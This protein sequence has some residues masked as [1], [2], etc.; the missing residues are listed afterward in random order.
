MQH[1]ERTGYRK[2]CT[3]TMH[4]T[5]QSL[6]SQLSQH[7][8]SWER[9]AA[10]EQMSNDASQLSVNLPAFEN[11]ASGTR[12]LGLLQKELHW[13]RV[14][15]RIQ[16]ATLTSVTLLR[17]LTKCVMSHLGPFYTYT[18][19]CHANHVYKMPGS[20]QWNTWR[21]LPTKPSCCYMLIKRNRLRALSERRNT[22]ISLPPP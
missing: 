5:Q 14:G 2:D 19:I 9:R 20:Q 12:N 3:T 21:G 8:N 1:R 22:L 13:T 11:Q 4:S 15:L 16:P 7:A 18:H 10:K 6:L 17:G